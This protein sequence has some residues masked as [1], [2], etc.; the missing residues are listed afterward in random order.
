M[1]PIKGMKTIPEFHDRDIMMGAFIGL[2]RYAWNNDEIRHQFE[3]ETRINL[4][5]IIPRNPIEAMIDEACGYD[6]KEAIIAFCDWV[7]VNL[8]GEEDK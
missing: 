1:I 2:I 8:W 7:N 5:H 3:Q 4:G 6:G